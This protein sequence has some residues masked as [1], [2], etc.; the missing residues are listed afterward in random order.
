MTIPQGGLH[1]L[2]PP[3]RRPMPHI[4]ACSREIQTEGQRPIMPEDTRILA[5]VATRASPDGRAVHDYLAGS[6][7]SVGTRSKSQQSIEL[8]L[9]TRFRTQAANEVS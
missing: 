8:E 5:T 7:S 9:G 2:K 4:C 6:P 1:S 3:E